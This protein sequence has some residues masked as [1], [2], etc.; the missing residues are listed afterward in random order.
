[1]KIIKT[2]YN[3]VILRIYYVSITYTNM[4]YISVLDISLGFIVIYPIF[5]L[6]SHQ[7]KF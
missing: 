2:S 5:K 7:M 4:I 1:M 3:K 6:K